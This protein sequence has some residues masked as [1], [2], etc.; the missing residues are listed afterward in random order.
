MKSRFSQILDSCL[1]NPMNGIF[2][3][4]MNKQDGRLD[5]ESPLYH[6]S[7]NLSRRLIEI[8]DFQSHQDNFDRLPLK[9]LQSIMSRVYQSK[10]ID[11]SSVI[12]AEKAKASFS[13]SPKRLEESIF[14]D[15]ENPNAEQSPSG[16]NSR[17]SKRLP[18]GLRHLSPTGILNKLDK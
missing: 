18:P 5:Y 13:T 12:K 9:K 8:L 3:K 14:H 1:T 15:P 16:E 6:D 10:I 7:E 4:K 17:Y 2:Y 11:Q